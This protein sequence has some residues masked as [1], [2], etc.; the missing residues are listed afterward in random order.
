MKMQARQQPLLQIIIAGMQVLPIL[1]IATY[2]SLI[3]SA[4]P[5]ERLAM[6]QYI[7]W[8]LWMILK[9]SY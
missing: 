9:A 8:V 5:M 2:A 3:L 4:T 7:D 1:D 6:L